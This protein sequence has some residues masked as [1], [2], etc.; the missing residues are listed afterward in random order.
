M[1]IA[2]VTGA[3]SGM[4]KQ[5]VL[6][7]S[8]YV[9]VDEIWAVAR[10][11]EALEKLQEECPV[12]RGSC[13]MGGYQH[14]EQHQIWHLFPVCYSYLCSVRTDDGCENAEEH[15]KYKCCRYS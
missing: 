9:E 3:S 6:Q 11:K 1:K 5:F 7:L 13:D 8:N 15:R 12:T 4:G 2:I 14:Y 10:R